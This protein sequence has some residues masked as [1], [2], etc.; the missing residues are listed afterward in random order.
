MVEKD[1]P[2]NFIPSAGIERNATAS[3]AWEE[4]EK[5][6]KVLTREQVA[7]EDYILFN[8]K[9]AESSGALVG[10]L[11]RLHANIAGNR[12][13]LAYLRIQVARCASCFSNGLCRVNSEFH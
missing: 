10:E 12:A 3:L 8:P 9:Y 6:A 2:K 1:D 7:K 11:G 13:F 4:E 5:F